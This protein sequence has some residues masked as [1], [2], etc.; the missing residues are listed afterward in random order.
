MNIKTLKKIIVAT[1]P[2]LAACIQTNATKPN[3][4]FISVDDLKPELGCYGNEIIKTPNIDKLAERGSVFLE[5]H[6]QQAVCGPSRASLLTGMRPDYT[7]VWDLKTLIRD[8]R[9]DIITLPQF[10]KQNGYITTG[11]GKIFDFRTVDW[12][13]DKASW[14]EPF[15][16]I[17]TKYY[18]N[19]TPPILYWYQEPE[20]RKLAQKYIKEANDQ[21]ITS[22]EAYQYA[23]QFVRPSTENF[24]AP[25]HAYSD[26]AITN[27]SIDIL[28]DLAQRQKPFFFAVG[29]S[30]P[31]LP[32]N[33]PAK[34]WNLYNRDQIPLAEFQE[35]AKG[36]PEIAYHASHELR[37][38]TDIPPLTSFSD[39]TRRIGLPLE[40]QKELIHGY[41]AS[42]SYIDAQIGKLITHLDSLELMENTIIVL[43]GDHG[44]HLGDHDLW[45]K[46][47]N[48]EQSTKSPLIIA[49]PKFDSSRSR[50]VV[51]F[52][53]I[54][55][56]LADLTGL[57]APEY[58]HGESLVP[59]MDNPDH[60]VKKFAVSQFP[61]WGKIMGYSIR[62]KRYRLTWWIKDGYRSYQQL[63]MKH[64]IAR[65]LYDY[66]KDPLETE[67]LIDK[68]AYQKTVKEL[69]KLM[70]DFFKSQYN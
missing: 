40:K 29:Y 41:Y 6:C 69:N 13:M 23:M 3:I 5:A 58:L 25:D 18:H 43:W 16:R 8:E 36:S 12:E 17:N 11:I 22:H 37:A 62:T 7:R 45:C 34:Y 63:D 26:G 46:H 21:G 19:Q 27:Q 38:Y 67:N 47:S 59:V 65:E 44:W 14:S 53:D 54:F 20:T 57:T 30:L 4:V 15:H 60:E 52:I 70:T 24:D 9:P 33:P 50:S 1:L 64:V 51:E 32:F 68:D 2:T 61:R 10:F 56:T 39:Q 28:Y 48:F 49:A 35:H 42:V 55:P 31:H 66:A